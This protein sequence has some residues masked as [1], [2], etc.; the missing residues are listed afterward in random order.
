MLP[1]KVFMAIILIT[2]LSIVAEARKYTN[3][4]SLPIFRREGA[5]MFLDRMHIDPGSMTINFGL[6]FVSNSP[7]PNSLY[8]FDLVAIPS[9]IWDLTRLKKC[10]RNGFS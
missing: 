8:E 7:K 4:L 2:L 5:W 1:I 9:S 3:S 10:D 6:K